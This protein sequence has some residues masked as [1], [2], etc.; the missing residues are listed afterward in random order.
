MSDE[1]DLLDADDSVE[2]SGDS[3]VAFSEAA[4]ALA[5]KEEERKRLQADV[6]A[7]LARGG[8]IER[9]DTNVMADAP[10]KPE[11]KYGGQPI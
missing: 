4:I 11:S 1:D 8:T 3:S 9:I 7:F 5:D 10:R 2:S 6:E